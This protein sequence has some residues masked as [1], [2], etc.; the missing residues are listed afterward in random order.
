MDPEL[1]RLIDEFDSQ[2]TIE[3]YIR[4]TRKCEER[5]LEMFYK[6]GIVNTNI[7]FAA[8]KEVPKWDCGKG[9]VDSYRFEYIGAVK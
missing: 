2:A 9:N 7:L 3:G 6:S 5:V 1:D 8:S 4:A